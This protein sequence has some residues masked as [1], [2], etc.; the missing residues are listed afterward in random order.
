MNL[1][2]ITVVV[3]DDQDLIRDALRALLSQ[4]DGLEVVGQASNGYEA[5]EQAKQLRPDVVLMDVK[6]PG[7]SGPDAARRIKAT[8]GLTGTSILMLTTFEDA[9]VV[10]ACVEAGA[11]GF[12]GK[13]GSTSALIE[14]IR[15]VRRGEMP[16]SPR[17]ARSILGGLTNQG[18]PAPPSDPRISMLTSRE[19]EIVRLVS[20]GL[21]NEEIARNLSISPATAQ[22]H[23]RNIMKKLQARDRVQ[24]VAF[25]YR[26]G[27][28][29]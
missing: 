7:L 8:R 18:S 16:L 24:L 17:A 19:V 21:S 11:D 20:N 4:A 12:I 9:E 13:G 14:A 3:A 25:A 2:P 15:A 22:T 26:T 10:H 23:V 5:V 1:R 27:L 28:T 29:E 6:M